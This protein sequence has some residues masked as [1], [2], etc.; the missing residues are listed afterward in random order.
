MEIRNKKCIITGSAQ[1]LGK[2]FAKILLDHGA[3]ICISDINEKVAIS[4]LQEFESIYGK[5]NVYFVKCDVANEEEFTNLFNEAEKYFKVD[6]VDI[7]VNNAGINTNFG[8]K[9][10]MDVNIMGVMIG[11]GIALKRMKENPNKG[12][13]INISSMAGQLTFVGE[14]IASYTVSKWGVV[15]LTRSLALEYEYHG[16]SVNAL[17]PA[18]AGTE[19]MSFSD[20][21]PSHLKECIE[22][23]IKT[24]GL[25]SLDYVAEGFYKLATECD[26]GSVMMVTNNVPCT[27]IPDTAKMKILGIA[28]FAKIIGKVCGINL[29]SVHHQKVFILM[30]TIFTCIL[31][32]TSLCSILQYIF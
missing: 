6:C 11:S 10:C 16:V 4:T 2:A 32:Y 9:K 28:I 12:S 7:L 30:F 31:L 23:S 15:V 29:V 21:M 27:I 14:Y 1:G 19:I 3:Q 17:C 18:W 22:K 5:Q 24:V 26:N 25:M 20:A 13:I 8:W